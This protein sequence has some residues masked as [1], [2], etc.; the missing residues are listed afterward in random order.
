MLSDVRRL[1]KKTIKSVIQQDAWLG[2]D[3]TL[4]RIGDYNYSRH[5]LRATISFSLSGIGLFHS[6]FVA[7]FNPFTVGVRLAWT[8]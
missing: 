5:L 4:Q 3:S 6:L 2:L 1:K 8:P 7:L